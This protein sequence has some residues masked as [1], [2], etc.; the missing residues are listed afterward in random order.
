MEP[1]IVLMDP[2]REGA[3]EWM[4]RI[5]EAAPDWLMYIS[6]NPLTQIRDLEALPEGMY[7]PCTPWP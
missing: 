1:S 7:V 2:P 5:A 4:E 3:K 6:C